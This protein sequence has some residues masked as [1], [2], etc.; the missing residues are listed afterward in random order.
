M[1]TNR[2]I[3]TLLVSCLAPAARLQSA[4]A[5]ELWAFTGPWDAQSDSS[6]RANA[7]R[8][9]VAVTGWIGLDSAT[10]QPIIPALFPDTM[11][12]ARASGLRRM[13][14]VTS[15]HGDRFHPSSIRALAGDNVHRARAAGA[16]A[17]HASAMRYAGLVLDFEALEARDLPSLLR[18][19]KAIADSAHAHG[20]STVA[21]AI[22]ATDTAAYPAKPIVGVADLVMPMLYDQ[23]WSTS[24]PGAISSP[25]WVRAALAARVGEVGAGRIVAAFPTYGYRWS[26]RDRTPA[27]VVSFAD[28]RRIAA[29]SHV[30]LERD[31]ASHTLRAVKPGDWEIWVSD[32]EL[33]GILARQ[34]R[35]AGVRR[36]ALWR[37]GPEDPGVWDTLER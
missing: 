33:L 4:P 32:A 24:R 9:D 30:S 5:S 1:S 8:L 17:M 35:D 14:I 7:A 11:Q 23:H 21:V 37:I 16:I 10:A 28:A 6:L 15:W 25:D 20:V 22:P 12:L 2:L 27:K 19:V 34:A 18:V 13:A 3:A 36:I 31:P 26:T 29:Q